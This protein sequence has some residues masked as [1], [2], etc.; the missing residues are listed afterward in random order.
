MIEK[1]YQNLIQ[2]HVEAAQV[3]FENWG[4][5][6]LWKIQLYIAF[7]DKRLSKCIFRCFCHVLQH[8][9]PSG[10]SIQNVKHFVATFYDRRASNKLCLQFNTKLSTACI[11]MIRNHRPWKEICKA[12]IAK[13]RRARLWNRNAAC[14]HSQSNFPVKTTPSLSLSSLKWFETALPTIRHP[15]TYVTPSQIEIIT[16]NLLIRRPRMSIFLSDDLW[17]GRASI[18]G[19]ARVYVTQ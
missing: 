17:F 6:R 8:V 13:L 19:G 10:I 15:A 4:K 18:Y 12:V 5:H 14:W 2:R 7:S 3:R 11:E 16:K 1:I 9:C